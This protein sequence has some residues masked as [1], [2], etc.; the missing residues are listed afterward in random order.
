M[1]KRTYTIDSDHED[2]FREVIKVCKIRTP[3]QNR[4]LKF[5]SWKKDG[6]VRFNIKHT[7]PDYLNAIASKWDQMKE[8]LESSASNVKSV[9]NSLNRNPL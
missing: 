2:L 6:F 9:F 8:V 7:Q 1:T 4:N 3:T 5:S